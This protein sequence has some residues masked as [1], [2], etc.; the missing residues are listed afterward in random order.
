MKPNIILINCDDLGFGDLG[1]CGSAVNHTPA[2]DRLAREGTCFT[3]FSMASSIC[4]PSRAAMLT[5]CYPQR[6]SMDRV[7]FPGDS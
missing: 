2:L 4:T 7:L 6:I 3:D 5:G 1:C